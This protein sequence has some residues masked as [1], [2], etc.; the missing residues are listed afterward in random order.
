MPMSG[1]VRS[2]SSPT[3]TAS[4]RWLP[5]WLLQVSELVVAFVFVDIS[6]HVGNGGLLVGAGAALAA[7]SITARGPLGILRICGQRLHVHAIAAV[8]VAVAVAPVFPAVR[9]DIEGIIIIEFGAI[10]LIRLATLTRIS[11]STPPGHQRVGSTDRVFDASATVVAPARP[12]STGSQQDSA[13]ASPS[14]GA[15][16]RWIGRTTGA[17]AA[18]GRRVAAHHRPEVEAQ[19]KR[20]IRGAGRVVGRVKSSSSDPEGPPS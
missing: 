7:L 11:A 8:A 9:P 4:R 18:S 3:A 10:G 15:A 16:A 5:F 20:T 19:V 12:A 2:A 13:G 17:A 1:E 6:I 14:T